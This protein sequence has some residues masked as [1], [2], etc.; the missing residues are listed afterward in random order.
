MGTTKAT[1]DMVSESYGTMVKETYG[2]E[3][4]EFYQ[5]EVV[6]GRLMDESYYQ[7]EIEV[8]QGDWM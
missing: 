8:F 3:N 6:K 2:K 1:E 4:V 7:V 5:M